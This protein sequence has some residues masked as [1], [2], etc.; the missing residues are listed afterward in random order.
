M[1]M[2]AGVSCS[3]FDPTDPRI[4]S[5]EWSSAMHEL[6]DDWVSLSTWAA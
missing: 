2:Q 1:K 3:A 4:S 6:W 5:S